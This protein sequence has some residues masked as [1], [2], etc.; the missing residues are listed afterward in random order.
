MRTF[1]GFSRNNGTTVSRVFLSPSVRAVA[2]APNL[3]SATGK[4]AGAASFA[5]ALPG[6]AAAEPGGG[7]GGSS[8]GA[9][10]GWTPAELGV[11]GDDIGA[12][13][14]PAARPP[15]KGRAITVGVGGSC[16][17]GGAG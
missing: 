3:I 6:S 15:G 4:S 8:G 9:G 11:M 7:G 16:G 13:A 17:D 2:S 12:R 14:P 10:G 5:A 1:P